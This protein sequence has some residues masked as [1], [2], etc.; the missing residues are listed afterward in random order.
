MRCGADTGGTFTD[1]VTDDG[2]VAKVLSTGED[3]RQAVCEAA[4]EVAGAP[5]AFLL[6]P[7]GR[8]FLSTAM[9]GVELP[10]V[11]IQP[12]G[13]A[14]PGAGRAFTSKDTYF[15]ADARS[16]PALAAPLVPCT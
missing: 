7:S 15:V 10:P 9:A 14:Q 11:T 5:V 1:V 13:D 12:R 8:D 2:R 16:H 4:C 3:A 6:E